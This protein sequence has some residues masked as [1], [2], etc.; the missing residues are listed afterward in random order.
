MHAQR[1]R[2]YGDPDY[3]TPLEMWRKNN[4][5]AQLRRFATVKADTYR[6][7]YGRHEH[8]AVAEAFVGRPLKA[9]EH[10]HHR[11]GNKH[12]NAPD[13]LVVLTRREHLALHAKQRR[14]PSC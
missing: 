12:N 14:S 8:R 13:N 7:L 3:V 2:R 1:M 10:V 11:D 9:D 5:D 4:R 6:K